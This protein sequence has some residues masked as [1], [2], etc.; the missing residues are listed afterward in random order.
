MDSNQY[1][2]MRYNRKKQWFRFCLGLM[3][4][5]EMPILNLM[6]FI[7]II[8]ARYAYKGKNILVLLFDMPLI[9]MKILD[10]CLSIGIVIFVISIVVVM[11]QEIGE[12]VAREDEAK[13]SLAFENKDFT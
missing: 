9:S 5:R 13:I 4:F 12:L 11:M 10:T 8:V 2:R 7:V 3:Q 6:W 1:N